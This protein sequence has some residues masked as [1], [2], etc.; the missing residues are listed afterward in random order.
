MDVRQEAREDLAA[1]LRW[2]CRL[3]L[4]EGVD[5]HY[6]VL[7][8]G[9]DDRFIINPHRR[10]WSDIRASDL[11]EV[12]ADGN[13]VVGMSRRS[14]RLFSSTGASM[15]NCPH[16]RD[17]PY[18]YALCDILDG[19]CWCAARADRSTSAKVSQ[20]NCLR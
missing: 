16:A 9:T 8:P 6:S 15:R 4:N 13:L 19:N 17:S 1:V 18:A 7:V 11:V 3:G 20:S 12:D 14:R 10:H 5:N 2:S